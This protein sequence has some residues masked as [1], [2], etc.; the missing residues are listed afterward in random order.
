[1]HAIGHHQG[2]V[3]QR[4]AHIGPVSLQIE[5]L[6]RFARASAMLE[7]VD[8]V[9]EDAPPAPALYQLLLRALRT[10]IT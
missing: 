10:P 1:M 8:Q 4:A 7:A 5:D 2:S 9:S 3:R 6:D